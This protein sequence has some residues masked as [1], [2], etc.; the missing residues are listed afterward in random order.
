MRSFK[1]VGMSLCLLVF[2]AMAGARTKDPA[3]RDVYHIT[4]TAP[5]HVGN[6]VLPAGDYTIHHEM[7]GQDH[8]MVFREDG[9]KTSDL[10]V[11]CTL[12]QLGYKASKTETIY[13]LNASNER[14]LQQIVFAGDTAKH[15]F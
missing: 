7:E 4:F 6:A 2:V 1:V 5:I 8:Y 3:I 10:K 9:K 11:K 13:E 12:V 14:V 15:V